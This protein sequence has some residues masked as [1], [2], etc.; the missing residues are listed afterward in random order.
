MRHVQHQQYTYTNEKK[1]DRFQNSTVYK[2]T[3]FARRYRLLNFYVVLILLKFFFYLTFVFDFIFNNRL[4]S[5]LRLFIVYSL[6]FGSSLVILYYKIFRC[7]SH[8]MK[9]DKSN[10][11]FVFAGVKFMDYDDF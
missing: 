9:C 8:V 11:T 10:K 1:T 3:C 5:V 4:L 6:M 7:F 2:S